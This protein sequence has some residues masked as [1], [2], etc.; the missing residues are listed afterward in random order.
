MASLGSRTA[1]QRLGTKGRKEADLSKT[2]LCVVIT[3]LTCAFRQPGLVFCEVQGLAVW[4]YLSLAF[5]VL[6]P[7]ARA[8]LAKVLSRLFL[9]ALAR[10]PG[11]IKPH[12]EKLADHF[13]QTQMTSD[14][15]T[16]F[17]AFVPPPAGLNIYIYVFNKLKSGCLL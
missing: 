10:R 8:R 16:R 6:G 1:V 2:L 7:R 11:A 3:G 4:N 12:N 5:E 13:Q 14:K 15:K 9:G 17:L